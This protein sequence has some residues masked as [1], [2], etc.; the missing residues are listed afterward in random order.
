MEVCHKELG[1]ICK[2]HVYELIPI[3]W[4]THLAL[5]HTDSCSNY[6]PHITIYLWYWTVA[7]AH[8]RPKQCGSSFTRVM[9]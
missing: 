2:C 7:L 1:E 3:L 8:K 6:G 5:S 9:S 4:C